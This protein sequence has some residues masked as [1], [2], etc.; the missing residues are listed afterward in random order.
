MTLIWSFGS[1]WIWRPQTSFKYNVNTII[2]SKDVLF[3]LIMLKGNF[4]CIWRRPIHQLHG[5][6]RLVIVL[7]YLLVSFCISSG[8]QCNETCASCAGLPKSLNWRPQKYTTISN[9]SPIGRFSKRPSTFRLDI[10][11][12]STSPLSAWWCRKEGS[13]L[14]WSQNESWRCKFLQTKAVPSRVELIWLT[15]RSSISNPWSQVL[16]ILLGH[17]ACTGGRRT[18]QEFVLQ[19]IMLNKTW[20]L[21]KIS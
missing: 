9:I 11:H 14:D 7:H 6:G 20:N 18:R 17:L 19:R 15:R 13:N 3:T 2:Y 5:Y 4:F 21:N 1:W 8:P 16:V 10:Q 12:V